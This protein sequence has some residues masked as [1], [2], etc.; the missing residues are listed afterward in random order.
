M[1]FP[2]FGLKYK[3]FIDQKCKNDAYHPGKYVAGQIVDEKYLG[4]GKIYNIIDQGGHD[5]P[6]QVGD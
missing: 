6:E 2:V 1:H 5:A 3:Y 4:A